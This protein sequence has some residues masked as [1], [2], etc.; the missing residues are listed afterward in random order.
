MAD[1]RIPE[2]PRTPNARFRCPRCERFVV[3][4]TG[5]ICPTCGFV[6]PVLQ[7]QSVRSRGRSRWA[8]SGRLVWAALAVAGLTIG[9]VLLS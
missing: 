3:A 6:P 4:G 7:P 1:E 9:Y 2:R 5:G 8:A